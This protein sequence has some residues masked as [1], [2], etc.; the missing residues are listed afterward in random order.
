MSTLINAIILPFAKPFGKRKTVLFTASIAEQSF[1]QRITADNASQ[2]LSQWIA[3][4][5]LSSSSFKASSKCFSVGFMGDAAELV[6][7]VAA[8]T[9]NSRISSTSRSTVSTSTE[10]TASNSNSSNNANTNQDDASD[11][12]YSDLFQ[13]V[14]V[15]F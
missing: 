5:S 4:V 12:S 7:V 2:L 13:Q 8:N 1:S 15:V 6:G 9:S 11:S 3:G 14:S 10:A